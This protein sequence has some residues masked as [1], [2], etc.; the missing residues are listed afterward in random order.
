MMAFDYVERE[1][2]G[3]DSG[4]NIKRGAGKPLRA[5]RT[6]ALPDFAEAVAHSNA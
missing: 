1:H 3:G 4:G 6:S 2:A 5:C